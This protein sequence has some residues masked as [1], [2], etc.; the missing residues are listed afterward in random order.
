[1][2]PAV[3]TQQA[4]EAMPRLIS[5]VSRELSVLLGAIADLNSDRRLWPNLEPSWPGGPGSR[6]ARGRLLAALFGLFVVAC[7]GV[8]SLAPSRQHVDVRLGMYVN[9]THAPALVGLRQGIFTKA[10]GP[11]VTLMTTTFSAG[12]DAV[13]ALLSNSIDATYIGPNPAINAFTQSHGRAVRIVSGATS[14]GASLVV[15]PAVA[16]PTDLRGKTLATPQLGNTQDVAL[17]YWLSRNGVKTAL[18]GRGDVS[19]HPQENAQ[20]LQTFRAGQIDGAWVPEPW[21]TRLVL[22]GGGKVLVDE[23]DLWPRGLFANTVLMVRTDFLRQHP[24]IVR[25]LIDGQIQSNA[26][27]NSQPADAQRIANAAI[28]EIT[29]KPLSDQVVAQAWGRLTFTDDPMASSLRDSAQHASQVGL[30]PSADLR[31]IFDLSLLN[32][33]LGAQGQPRVLGA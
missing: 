12:P 31:G 28:N 9:L 3:R 6:P 17:R 7:G 29:G 26:L 33:A 16:S 4:K 27:I 18:E 15:K 5:L 10:L 13:T 1:M 21:A 30:L 24:A 19:I 20:T 2:P 8:P 32:Q 25:R 11:A 23:R 22:E 14:G